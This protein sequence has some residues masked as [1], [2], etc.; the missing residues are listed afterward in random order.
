MDKGAHFFKCDFQVHTP[1]DINW[2]GKPAITESERDAY[3]ETLIRACR[4]KGI[5]AIA[6]TDHHDLTFFSYVKKASKSELND[7]G[8]LYS[9]EEQIV[10]FPGVELTLSAPPCQAILILDSEFPENLFQSVLTSL[11][12]VPN[13]DAE[14]KTAKTTAIP[15]VVVKDFT[16]LYERLNSL[17]YVKGHFIIFPHVG[18]GGHKTL[19]RSGFYDYYKTMPCVGGYIEN[20][21]S[22]MGTG[23]VNIIAGKHRDYGFKQI[24]VIQTSDNRKENHDDLGK[25]TTWVK[26]AEPTAEALR[27]ACLAKD[28]RISQEAPILPPIYITFLEIT[29]S[30]F[31]GR[32]LIEF[33]SQYNAIIGG[34]GTG[35]STVLEYLRWGLCDQLPDFSKEEGE[36]PNYQDRRRKL[37]EKTL[38]PFDATVQVSFIKNGIPHVV[39]RKSSSSDIHIKVG[40][41]EFRVCSEEDVRSLLPIQAY[42]QKQLSN[43]GVSNSELKRLIYSPIRDVLSD[44]QASFKS[45]ESDIRTCYE[46]RTQRKVLNSDIDRNELEL[47]SLIE[48]VEFLRKGLTGVVGQD[49]VTVE[50]HECY[51]IIENLMGGWINE[52]HSTSESIENVLSEIRS[53][54]TPIPKDITVPSELTQLIMNINAEIE[55]LFETIKTKLSAV[56]GELLEFDSRENTFNVWKSEWSEIIKKHKED[57]ETAKENSSS[58]EVTLSQITKLEGRASEV[59]KVALEGRQQIARLGD[60]DEEFQSLR[61]QWVEKH[62]IRTDIVQSQCDRLNTL[63]DNNLKVELGRCQGTEALSVLLKGI[64]AGSN[65]RKDKIDSLCGLVSSSDNPMIEWQEVLDELELLA[66]YNVENDSPEHL[67]KPEKLSSLGFSENDLSR[68]AEKINASNFLELLLIQL[69]DI[70]TF[71]YRT[72]EGEYI[73]FSDASAGQQ[74]TA[75]IHV[76]LNQE[77]PTLIIDQPEDD[78]DNQMVSEIADLIC[79]AKRKRQLIFTSHNANIVVNGDAEL[80]AC[81][82]Y[83]VSGDQSQGEIKHVGAIDMPTIKDQITKIMEG[84]EKAFRLRKEKYGF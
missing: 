1:R 39:R 77:G 41:D 11:S 58:Q 76:L 34:R 33:N 13:H 45:L 56:N 62:R 40:S 14:S 36:L 37:I 28:S 57:Y 61:S 51:S 53:F 16:N 31:L 15:N 7:S 72:R 18:D 6:I 75:L 8:H 27:Q 84:G 68:M 23:N 73:E 29:N 42:S 32:V 22:S 25:H 82:D 63:S 47:K 69:E 74:A 20:S 55:G 17:Q 43:V 24:A 46:K 64:V 5:Q 54:P 66:M 9:P 67:P 19:L 26:W 49:R 80:V 4:V 10:I 81:C 65:I 70:P 2:N 44:V 3:A 52:I 50:S 79:S 12:I 30:K 35:K 60:R 21:I 83:V 59:R 48:Q 38:F 71:K 78:L